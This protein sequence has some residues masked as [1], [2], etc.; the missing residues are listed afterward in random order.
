MGIRSVVNDHS[1]CSD[2]SVGWM[3]VPLTEVRDSKEE[4][5]QTENQSPVS[6]DLSLGASPVETHSKHSV[7]VSG[8][9]YK[10]LG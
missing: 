4:E 7:S 1:K 2:L 6:E 9:Q 3:Q 5:I 10:N 8:S